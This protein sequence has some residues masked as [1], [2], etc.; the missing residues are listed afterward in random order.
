MWQQTYDGLLERM[1]DAEAVAEGDF[2]DKT[3]RYF[4]K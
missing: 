3:D 4:G 1:W 2:A